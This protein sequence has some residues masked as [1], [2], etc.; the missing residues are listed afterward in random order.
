MKSS[1]ALLIGSLLLTL[2]QWYSF[3][4]ISQLSLFLFPIILGVI[5]FILGFIGAYFFPL[6][7]FI[8]EILLSVSDSALYA[9]QAS[10]FT[11]LFNRKYR[12][13]A[14]NFSYQIASIIGGSIAPAVLRATNYNVLTVCIPYVVITIICLSL[15][16]ET[17][18]ENI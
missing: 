9:P 11:E 13:T 14:S 17:K 16:R 3:F 2:I 12:F 8:G 4:L 5:V 15:I 6:R 1:L 10:L 7:L 18:G